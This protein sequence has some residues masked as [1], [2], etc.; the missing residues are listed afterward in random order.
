MAT[1][2][3]GDLPAEIQQFYNMELLDRAKPYL[4]H[5][6][7]SVK[8]NIP[9]N[10]GMSIQWRR[11]ER[12]SASSTALTEGTS[13]AAIVPTITAITVTLAQYGQWLEGSDLLLDQSIDQVLPEFTDL[14][15]QAMAESIDLVD[16][17]V[18]AAGTTIQYAST[19]ASRAA[20]GSGMR[21][22]TAE[23]IEAVNTL[24]RNEG[25]PVVD[26]FYACI[27]HPD[28]ARDLKQDP[29]YV[30]AQLYAGPRDNSNS[31][32]RGT[33][34]DYQGVR[35]CETTQARIFSSL[36]LSGADVYAT[37]V[38]ADQSYATTELEKQQGRIIYH[39]PGNG[40]RVDPLDQVFTLGYKVA[41]TAK[42][43]NNDWLVRI[44]H[45]T[46]RG[47]VG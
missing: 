12:L 47:A 15:S 33:L 20:V 4:V 21:L 41:H 37:L 8:K 6:Q 2:L 19:A 45:T 1:Q 40:G 18:L 32:V 11:F 39:A 31:I 17:G 46:T 16:R 23:I 25:K 5:G 38:I 7:F 34:N 36:G 43:L 29:S 10:A 14:L 30:A 28:A 22:N 27:L 9:A 13:G 26:G 24:A 42:I 3:L 35:F 44:E